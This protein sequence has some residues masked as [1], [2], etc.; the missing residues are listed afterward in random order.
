MRAHVQC[1]R[2]LQL[3]EKGKW[4]R[5][6]PDEDALAVAARRPGTLTEKD[7]FFIII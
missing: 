1:A 2:A 7:F 4:A 6:V 5:R 3:I